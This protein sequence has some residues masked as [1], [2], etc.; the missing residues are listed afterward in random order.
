MRFAGGSSPRRGRT[1]MAWRG[2]IGDDDVLAV[3]PGLSG[4]D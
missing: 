2:L 4:H 3:D 1:A